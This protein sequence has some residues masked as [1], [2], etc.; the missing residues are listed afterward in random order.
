MS[1]ANP[2]QPASGDGSVDRVGW[3]G[4]QFRQW[5]PDAAI[6]LMGVRAY[7]PTLGRFLSV[8]PVY[9]GS[10]NAYD[11]VGGDPINGYDLD[12]RAKQRRRV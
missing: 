8:D 9:G 12:G 3:L 1:M 7:D 6:T 11:Y 2:L 5:D 10:A 4:R